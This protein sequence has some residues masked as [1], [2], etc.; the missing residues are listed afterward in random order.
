MGCG[1]SSVGCH[2]VGYLGTAHLE[3]VYLGALYRRLRC[4]PVIISAVKCVPSFLVLLFNV[5]TAVISSLCSSSAS[6]LFNL[7]ILE[8]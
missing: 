5:I 4:S 3:E 6:G 1:V 2:R 8:R 7:A